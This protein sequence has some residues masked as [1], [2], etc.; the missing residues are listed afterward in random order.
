[1]RN[2]LEYRLH[3]RC[4]AAYFSHLVTPTALGKEAA[5]VS[6]RLITLPKV[7]ILGTLGRIGLTEFRWTLALIRN[8]DL[9]EGPNPWRQVLLGLP[10]GERG[11]P[12]SQVHPERRG[13]AFVE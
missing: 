3:A 9:L 4:L 11:W 6:N 5:F 8:S 1:L 7:A 13:E 10:C 12:S 2:V